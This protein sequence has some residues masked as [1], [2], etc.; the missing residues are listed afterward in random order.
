[1]QAKEEVEGLK[2]KRDAILLKMSELR[3]ELET[4]GV[5]FA[6][7]TVE[8]DKLT[9]E[10]E[11]LKANY[12]VV[13]AEYEKGRIARQTQASD[14][15]IAGKA[16]VP[17]EPSSTISPVIVLAAAVVGIILTCGLLIMKE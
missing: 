17:D 16:V 12:A 11:S 6:D 10:Q 1:V 8:R 3:K 5:T 4:L 7:Q 14:I 15:V 9:R 2:A 13:R